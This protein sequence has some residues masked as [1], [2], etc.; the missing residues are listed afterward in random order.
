MARVV[1]IDGSREARALCAQLELEGYD[2]EQFDDPNN[3]LAQLNGSPADVVLV[4]LMIPG[5]TGL[6]FARTIRDKC[7]GTRVV[8]TGAYHLSERQLV[9][10]DCGAIGFVPKP[11]GTREVAA[12]LQSKVPSTPPSF[13]AL[14]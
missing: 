1:V 14:G 7:P 4:D 5:T 9:R 13:K 3:A 10:A 11:Y 12:F 8:L 6:A 2:V